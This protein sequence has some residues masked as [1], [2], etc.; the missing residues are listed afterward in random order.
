MLIRTGS[1]NLL[2][3]LSYLSRTSFHVI[4][5]HMRRIRIPSPQ[6]SMQCG[7]KHAGLETK[8][9]NFSAGFDM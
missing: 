2:Y 8:T 4:K 5:K 3:P 9:Q 6:E 7:G 1:H